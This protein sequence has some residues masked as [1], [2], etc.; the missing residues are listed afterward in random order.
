MENNSPKKITIDDWTFRVKFASQ[1]NDASRLMVLLHGHLGNENVMWVFTKHLSDTYTILAPR[2]PVK[3]GPEEQFSW[4]K[5]GSQWPGIETYQELTNQ[6]MARVSTFVNEH[7]I[8][9]RKIDVM[10]FSQGASM[11]Y[12]LAILHPDKIG[13]VAAIAGFIPRSWKE[14]INQISIKDK[15]FFIAHG[16]EDD[17]I[18][19]EKARQA[20]DWLRA[21][22]AQVTFCE[23]D[24]GH[25]ISANCF[26]GLGDF[27]SE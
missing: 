1:E 25:K 3:T 7:K 13:K 12:A 15:E 19:I 9:D 11:A 18:P 6:L 23:A 16:N 20:A 8:P 21:Q 26:N 22:D 2:A 5:I 4:H 17:I 10:G 24:T 27:F 14:S